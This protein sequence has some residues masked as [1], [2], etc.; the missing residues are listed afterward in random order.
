MGSVA[1]APSW[2]RAASAVSGVA[3][4]RVARALI[5]HRPL[6]PRPRACGPGARRGDNS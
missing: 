5:K 2:T 6:E 4:A 3:Q 1:H